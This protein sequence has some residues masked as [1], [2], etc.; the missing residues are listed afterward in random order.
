MSTH[1]HTRTRNVHN[2]VHQPS[3]TGP[4][5]CMVPPKSRS[6]PHPTNPCCVLRT[7]FSP[8]CWLCATERRRLILSLRLITRALLSNAV[9]D[10]T[11]VSVSEGL[12]STFQCENQGSCTSILMLASSSLSGN[13]SLQVRISH[14]SVTRKCLTFMLVKTRASHFHPRNSVSD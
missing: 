1:T 6:T 14:S 11:G 2:W 13:T 8:T 4:T 7:E 9:C 12:V 10:R 5:H 3:Q